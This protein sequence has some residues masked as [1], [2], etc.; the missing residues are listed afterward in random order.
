MRKKSIVLRTAVVCLLTAASTFAQ[1]PAQ[2]TPAPIPVPAP[3]AAQPSQPLTE[4]AQVRNARSHAEVG[5]AG[6]GDRMIV[7]VGNFK[8]LLDAAGGNCADIMLFLDTMPMNLTP[9]S[10]NPQDG[11]VRYLLVRNEKNDE[12]W[13]WLLGTPHGFTRKI[14]VSVGTGM[15]AIDTLVT[16]FPIRVIPKY[17]FYLWILFTFV[18]AIGFIRLCR[19]TGLI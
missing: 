9:E 18:G 13:H 5:V 14:R 6:L 1:Q 11:T 17:A 12:A 15:N 7:E 10:C 19:T 2:Q 3:A 4:Y 8:K 16:D